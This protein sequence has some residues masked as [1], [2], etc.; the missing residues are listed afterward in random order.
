MLSFGMPLRP[1][2]WDAPSPFR[3]SPPFISYHSLSLSIEPRI[4]LFSRGLWIV[5]R[6]AFQT[7]LGF[8]YRLLVLRAFAVVK[9]QK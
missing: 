2:L 6:P 7:L 8:I 1:Y 3:P 9:G 4:L 5:W